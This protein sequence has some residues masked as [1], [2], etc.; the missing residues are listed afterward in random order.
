MAKALGNGPETDA[1][2]IWNNIKIQ[3]DSMNS[4]KALAEYGS[5]LRDVVLNGNPNHPNIVAEGL[6][7]ARKRYLQLDKGSL[8]N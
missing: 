3:V 5:L 7:Y 2:T 4:R 1:A 6:E 8:F